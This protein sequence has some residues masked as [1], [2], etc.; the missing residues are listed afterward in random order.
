M[1]DPEIFTK[2]TSWSVT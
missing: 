1:S 2:Y